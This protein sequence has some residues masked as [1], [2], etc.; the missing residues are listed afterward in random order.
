MAR[1]AI[2]EVPTASRV[3][4]D[5]KGDDEDRKRDHG[6]TSVMTIEDAMTPPI[7]R[8]PDPVPFNS[9]VAAL[10]GPA[11]NRNV[12]ADVVPAVMTC[13]NVNVTR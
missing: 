11:R 10:S 5:G 2:R 7:K 6:K 9:I 8:A 1:Q 12:V 4:D 13:V 3:V